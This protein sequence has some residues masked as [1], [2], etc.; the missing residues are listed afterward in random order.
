MAEIVTRVDDLDGSTDDV[1]NVKFSFRGKS[2]GIDLG[3]AGR[4]KLADALSPFLAK[5]VEIRGAA[6]VAT[7]PRRASASSSNEE[8]AAIR[9]WAQDNKVEYRNAQGNMTTLGERGRIPEEVKQA[10]YDAH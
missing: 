10:Y 5:A 7:K 2:Y 3:P 9:K 8:M 6:A 1:Q 4:E